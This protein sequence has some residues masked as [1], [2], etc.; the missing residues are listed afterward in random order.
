MAAASVSASCVVGL[1]LPIRSAR[2]IRFAFFLLLVCLVGCN[3]RTREVTYDLT[4]RQT[5]N[6]SEATVV[7][8]PVELYIAEGTQVRILVRNAT[9]QAHNCVLVQPGRIEEALASAGSTAA[10][11]DARNPA[12]VERGPWIAPQSSQATRFA[13]PAPG[14]YEFTCTC[15]TASHRTPLRGKLIVQ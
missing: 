7:A 13:A 14:H 3:R 2:W 10:S 15:G 1:C 8:E 5:S 4:L 12:V 6:G 9:Q 11:A